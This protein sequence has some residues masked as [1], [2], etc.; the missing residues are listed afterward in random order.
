[1]GIENEVKFEVSADDLEKLAA[2]R[3]LASGRW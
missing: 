1:M 2:A 3:S